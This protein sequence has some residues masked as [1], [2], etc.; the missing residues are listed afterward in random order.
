MAATTFQKAF[1]KCKECGYEWESP[2]SARSRGA[3]N[4]YV[5]CP[6]C[7]KRRLKEGPKSLFEPVYCIELNQTFISLSEASRQTGAN[8]G[9]IRDNIN[10]KLGRAGRIK[11]ADGRVIDLHWKWA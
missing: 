5:G 3:N 2:I 10:G 1:W 7:N 6:S 8:K 11:K 4:K 9:S